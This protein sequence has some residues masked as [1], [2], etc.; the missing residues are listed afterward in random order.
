MNHNTNTI[1]KTLYNFDLSNVFQNI[2]EPNNNN[3]NNINIK[4][5]TQFLY[6]NNVNFLQFISPKNIFH[7]LI[8]IRIRNKFIIDNPHLSNFIFKEFDKLYLI[9]YIHDDKLYNIYNS[10]EYINIH[11]NN[12]NNELYTHLIN[13]RKC[14]KLEDNIFPSIKAKNYFRYMGY[15]DINLN[16]QNNIMNGNGTVIHTGS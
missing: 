13:F 4:Q 1:S 8:I 5:I 11:E 14:Y 7:H 9:Y 16:F 2:I 10:Y 3:N 6:N 12:E 15:H